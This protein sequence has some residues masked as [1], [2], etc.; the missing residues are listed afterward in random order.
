M[1][2]Q[3]NGQENYLK[4]YRPRKIEEGARFQDFIME[5]MHR[6]GMVL[7]FYTSKEGQQRGET[8]L[9]LEVKHDQKIKKWGNLC[10]EVAEKAYPRDGDYAPSGIFRSDNSW[11][12]GIGDYQVFYIFAKSS[13]RNCFAL[14]D[15]LGL[16]EYVIATSKGFKLPVEK[17][18]GCGV[19][20]EQLK[21]RKVIF[22]FQGNISTVEAGG[23]QAPLDLSSI[24]TPQEFQLRLGI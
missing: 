8:L 15:K 1:N 17:R 19:C 16:E 2:F 24:E 4:E 9:G 23:T 14:R 5:R 21:A 6:L 18:N 10:I 20:A 13:L 22:D 7:Q 11:L 3:P 12:Y